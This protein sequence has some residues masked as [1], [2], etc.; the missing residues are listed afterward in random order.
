MPL[1]EH[2]EK[3]HGDGQTGLE[4]FRDPMFPLLEVTDLGPHRQDGFGEHAIIPFTAPA[5]LQIGRITGLSMKSRV[6]Q[7]HY[8]VLKQFDDQVKPTVLGIRR[9][10]DP[11]ADGPQMIDDQTPL[12]ADDPAMIGNP[13]ASELLRAPA[14]PNGVDQFNAKTV[15]NAQQR[16]LRQ[17][18]EG[19]RLMGFEQAKPT[20]TLR[21]VRKQGPQVTRQ[22][23]VEGPITDPFERVQQPQGDDFTWPQYGLGMF[24]LIRHSVG[25]PAKQR[26]DK[27]GCG[28]VGEPSADEVCCKRQGLGVPIWPSISGSGFN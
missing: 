6:I 21:Q 19:P 22:P 16:W 26:G 15:H 2:A 18:L 7:D 17:K 28:S 25:D 4:I 24:V 8:V 13:L 23:A 5:E 12:A 3:G 1:D 9:C 14:L 10:P 27:V 11:A 20:G